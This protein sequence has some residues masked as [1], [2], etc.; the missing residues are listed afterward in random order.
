MIIHWLWHFIWFLNGLVLF[1]FIALNSVYLVTSIISIWSLKQYSRQLKSVDV[2]DLLSTAG[3]PPI[4]LIAPAFNE[5]ATCV[6]SVR[7]LLTLLYPDY[8]IL[9]VNDGS[10][11]HTLERMLEAYDMHPAS[12]FPTSSIPTMP[13]QTIYRSR[14]YPH[15]Y[16]LD[17][18]NGG[19]ADALNA[20]INY[21]RTPLFCAMDADTLLERD[22]LIRVVRPFLESDK[23]V[24]VGGIIRI[25]ND[26]T[27]RA[28]RK[29]VV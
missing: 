21:C 1:Y 24:A 18:K 23:T 7:S 13:I 20:G 19:K 16:L 14:R 28:D 3:A 10:K 26:C 8:E 17:K 25:V 6:E 4:T 9:F 29:S 12:R 11:D 2:E 22:A 5:E 15:L 27:V